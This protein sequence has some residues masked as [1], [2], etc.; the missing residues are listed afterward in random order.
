MKR[1]TLFTVGALLAGSLFAQTELNGIKISEGKDF[2]NYHFYRIRNMRAMRQDF[3]NGVIRNMHG[4]SINCDADGFYMSET[5]PDGTP[6]PKIADSPYMGLSNLAGNWWLSFASDEDIKIPHTEYW[7]FTTDRHYPG[8]VK[9]QN[10]VITGSVST[11]TKHATDHA[12]YVR[13][14]VDFNTKSNYLYVLPVKPAFE[15][16]NTETESWTDSILQYL[17]EE[18]LN[19]AFAFS[20]RDTISDE[21]GYAECIEVTNKVN[22]M[23]REPM[24]TEQGDTIVNEKGNY[25]FYRYGFVGTDIT[26]SPVAASP[27]NRNHWENNGS[28]FIL[29]P[30]E[31]AEVILA[32]QEFDDNNDY[33]HCPDPFTDPIN[34]VIST[35]T[36]WR[37]LPALFS[38]SAMEKLTGIQNWLEKWVIEVTELMSTTEDSDMRY[39][40]LNSIKKTSNDKLNEAAALVGNGCVVRFRNQLSLKDLSDFVNG[41]KTKN[42]EL[43]LGN[44]YLATGGDPTYRFNGAIY[45]MSHDEEFSDRVGTGIEPRL[46]ADEKCEWELIPVENA[47]TFLLY[48]KAT[49]SYIRKYHDMFDYYGGEEAF[50]ASLNMIDEF[51]WVTTG[52]KAEAAPF[53]FIACS[54]EVNQTKLIP[55]QEDLLIAAG[56]NT[57]IENKVRLQAR[58]S[59]EDQN[60]VTRESTV[61]NY[62]FNIHRGSRN[63]DYRFINWG[64]T[65]NNWFADSNA[66]LIESVQ[67]GGIDEITADKPAQATGIYDL[68][69]RR[70]SNPGKGLYIVDGRKT[71][72][73]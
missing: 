48:N 49:D 4:D 3:T 64:N 34:S 40:L 7:Y 50:M 66:F 17:S 22:I 14:N 33:H 58:Y 18:D 16:M 30:V 19:R 44:A 69:G 63:S 47:A 35:I 13:S 37:N 55:L 65:F 39:A 6:T 68:Q 27:Y 5:L 12:G 53:T 28:I 73:R 1:I 31:T 38:E 71:L 2:A 10:A 23:K 32:K 24:L 20:L 57:G 29:E 51:S 70:I 45:Y 8:A 54:D 56:L 9:I 11:N 52:N 67:M 61:T 60:P 59:E 62:S 15:A 72:I 43:Q 42:E 46:Q 36:G 21:P 25:Q 41:D 26:G